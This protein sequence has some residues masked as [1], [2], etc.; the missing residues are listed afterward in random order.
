M[1]GGL[2]LGKRVLVLEDEAL[3]A[4]L[5]GELIE[6]A[7]GTAEV[8]HTLDAAAAAAEHTRPDLA[9]LDINIHGE[10]SFAVAAQ[11]RA[12]GVPIVFASGY[13][14]ADTPPDMVAVPVVTKPYG[15][16]ELERAFAEAIA[17][18]A[19]A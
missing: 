19:G 13:S 9:I 3:I 16:P 1:N 7:G 11:L 5:L 10:P 8:T 15:L 6:A 4:M 17:R 12:L 18:Q 14:R 2:F